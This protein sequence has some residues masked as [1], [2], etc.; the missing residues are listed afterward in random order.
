MIDSAKLLCEIKK[1]NPKFN[2]YC[3]SDY[4]LSGKFCYRLTLAECD[5]GFFKTAVTSRGDLKCYKS[6]DAV[7]SDVRRYGNFTVNILGI[8]YSDLII[9]MGH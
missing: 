9:S 3:S 1:S 4:T 8:T 6:I 7:V 2:F 5:G